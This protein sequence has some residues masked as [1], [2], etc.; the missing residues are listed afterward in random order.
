MAIKLP[1]VAFF[2]PAI[3]LSD[4]PGVSL[5][6]RNQQS[7]VIHPVIIIRARGENMTKIDWHISR[8]WSLMGFTVDFDFAPA[9]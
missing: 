9:R 6:G 1:A 4:V 3:V 7:R 8:S 2:D 5:E